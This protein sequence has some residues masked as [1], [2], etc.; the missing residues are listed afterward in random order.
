MRSGGRLR[1]LAGRTLPGLTAAGSARVPTRGPGDGP[2]EVQV[3]V[4]LDLLGAACSSGASVPGAL[5]AVGSAVGGAR[6]GVLERGAAALSLGASWAEAWAD[7]PA[8]LA[9]VADALRSSWE[10][11][12]APAG[13]L[14]S[15]A[16]VLRRERHAR[17]LEEAGRLGVR[18][19]LPLG[20][21]Y[22]PAFVLVGLVPVLVSMAGGVLR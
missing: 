9:P 22:L 4:L 20:L 19:V 7:A 3:A 17:A 8:A 13:A 12:A 16:A 6:G 14:R 15:A 1:V 18:L 10:D 5:E 2:G 21:C 11:G